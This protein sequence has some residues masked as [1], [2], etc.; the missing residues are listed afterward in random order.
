MTQITNNIHEEGRDYEVWAERGKKGGYSFGAEV[1]S[2]DLRTALDR[3][4]IAMQS[5]EARY[6]HIEKGKEEK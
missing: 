2:N 3:L 4:D 1:K 6:G 5:L